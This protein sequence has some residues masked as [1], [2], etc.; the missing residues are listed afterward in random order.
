MRRR[1][2]APGHKMFIAAGSDFS[3]GKVWDVVKSEGQKR[4]PPPEW[5]AV[6]KALEVSLSGPLNHN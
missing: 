1:S 2:A 3:G 6:L 5:A 4:E